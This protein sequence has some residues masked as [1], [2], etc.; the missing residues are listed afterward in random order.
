MKLENYLSKISE[1]TNKLGVGTYAF[2]GQGNAHWPLHSAATRRLRKHRGE[3][4]Q[5]SPEFPNLYLDYHKSTLLAPARTRGLGVEYGR[6]IS[7]LQLLAKLQHLGAATGLLDF[8]WSPLV[9]IWFACKDCGVDGKLYVINTN[10]PI[11]VAMVLS[12]E[13]ELGVTTLF[14]SDGQYPQIAYWEPIAGGDA[15]ARILRQRSVFVIGRPSIPEDSNVKG[16]ITIA[17]EDKKELIRVLGL[18][19]VS[20]ESLFLDAPGFAEI[21]RVSNAVSLS[22]D[23]YLIAGNRYYQQGHYEHAVKAYDSLLYRRPNTYWVY[24]LRANAHAELRSHVKAIEDYNSAIAVMTRVPQ[25]IH[26]GHMIYFNRANS[27]VE[28]GENKEAVQDYLQAIELAPDPERFHHNLANTYADMLCFEEAT[29][30][31]DKVKP[32]HWHSVFNKGNA[33]ICLGKLSEAYECYIQAADLAPNNETVKQNLWTTTELISLLAGREIT[34]RLDT[35]RMHLHICVTK[36][37]QLLEFPKRTYIIAGRAGN[38]GNSGFMT[39]GGRG[40]A[41]KGSIYISISNCDAES[42]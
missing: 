25:S 2:R 15:T 16:K 21:N 3:G 19:D 5:S 17:K 10:D 8:T 18:L 29:L 31:Y 39:S 35:S 40:F 37:V 13:S 26:I 1:V 23:D 11:Q 41:G 6:E 34:Q 38:V 28:L 7:E 14:Q 4:I 22:Q 30:A 42:G 12:D 27:K 36:E 32:P 33:L 24:F 20:H 9:G